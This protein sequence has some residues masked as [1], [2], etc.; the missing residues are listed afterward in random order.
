MI[1]INYPSD[2]IAKL[3][4]N[5]EYYYSIKN[6]VN[7]AKIDDTLNRINFKG[8]SLN[9][10]ILLTSTFEDLIEIKNV[11]ELNFLFFSVKKKEFNKLFNYKS[12]QP[13]IAN[14]FMKMNKKR[15]IDFCSCY[16]CNIDFINVFNDTGEYKSKVD[17]INAASDHELSLIPEVAAATI[18]DIK[19][20]RPIVDL[21]L[22]FLKPAKRKIFNSISLREINSLKNHFTLDHFL[23]QYNFQY[24]SLSL[25]NLIPSCYSCNSK[26]KG[27]KEFKDDNNL[28]YLSPSCDLFLLET[29]PL[30][31][32][33]F[34]QGKNEN[35]TKKL[36]DFRIEFDS[37]LH[38][39][40]Q[41]LDI[42]KIKGRYYFHKR[43][44]LNLILKRQIYSDSN[45]REISQA[46]RFIRDEATIK[47]DLFGSSI[48]NPEEY[49]QPLTKYKKDIARKIGII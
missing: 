43:E 32:L 4:F 13:T 17:F 42:F 6:K 35:N 3:K 33:Y 15:S 19:N 10:K 28:I 9:F 7:E 38:G 2:P 21:T 45:I 39:E 46:L 44:A 48:F 25:Y 22:T 41:F 40:E 12:L 16:Y 23:P 1:K 30:F 18:R 14:A 11:L 34:K 49:N 29:N 47:K 26:F 24:L 5:N 8:T 27:I 36:S 20:N 31:K 37:N